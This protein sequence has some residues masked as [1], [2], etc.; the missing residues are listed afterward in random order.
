MQGDGNY[1][2]VVSDRVNDA[3]VDVFEELQLP[4]ERNDA[5]QKSAFRSVRFDT[6]PT[7]DVEGRP[8]AISKA[9]MSV[10]SR[11]QLKKQATGGKRCE[12]EMHNVKL[13]RQPPQRWRP[14]QRRP[15]RHAACSIFG[16]GGSTG[17]KEINDFTKNPETKNYDKT[18]KSR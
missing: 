15:L 9:R 12:K 5:S 1:N 4:V 2:C 18:C 7:V 17:E 14:P 11:R 13:R 3:R 6:E 8:I 16:L 10:A